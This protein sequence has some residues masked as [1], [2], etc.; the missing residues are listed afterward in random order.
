MGARLAR[1]GIQLPTS[2]SRNAVRLPSSTAAVAWGLAFGALAGHVFAGTIAYGGT[3]S[4]CGTTGV[5]EWIGTCLAAGV[6]AWVGA[7]SIGRRTNAAG[8]VVVGLL[9]AL[10]SGLAFARWFVLGYWWEPLSSV[11]GGYLGARI[12]PHV[13]LAASRALSVPSRTTSGALG[14]GDPVA[15]WTGA[16]AAVVSA[17]SRSNP[18]VHIAF[19]LPWL[20][21]RPLGGA[22]LGLLCARLSLALWSLRR[23]REHP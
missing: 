17:L 20:F 4:L 21:T 15:A 14:R 12:A 18:G 9:A 22:V 16:M 13:R 7:G 23:E 5:G 11:V 6:A 8:G 19:D 2:E 10:A 1:V 3:P